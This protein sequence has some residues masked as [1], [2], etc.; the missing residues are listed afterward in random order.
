[1]QDIKPIEYISHQGRRKNFSIEMS[2]NPYE[3]QLECSLR[4]HCK[5]K[6][7]IYKSRH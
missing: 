4:Q 1:M 2:D 6:R 5:M 3:E 7:L